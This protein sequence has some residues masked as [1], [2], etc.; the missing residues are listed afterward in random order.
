MPRPWR[1]A[2]ATAAAAVLAQCAVLSVAQAET[3]LLAPDEG[4]NAVYA[5]NGLIGVVIGNAYARQVNEAADELR[6]ASPADALLVGSRTLRLPAV[7]GDATSIEVLPEPVDD[8]LALLLSDR[9]VSE[10]VLLRYLPVADRHFW[11]R[12][13]V[14]KVSVNAGELKF[15]HVTNLYYVTALEEDHQR[16]K[17]GWSE[18]ALARIADE[19]NASFAELA[20]MWARVVADTQDGTTTQE[21]WASLP[22]ALDPQDGWLIKCRANRQ[23]CKQQRVVRLGESRAWISDSTG[24][25]LASVDRSVAEEQA[26]FWTLEMPVR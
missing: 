18:G 3:V 2:I 1:I 15:E 4:Y 13:I 10:A 7:Y 23:A 20:E 11:A 21:K 22:S 5:D 8:G 25:G 12:L 16:T 14:S 9:G 26:L 6:A 24:R 17:K 19:M